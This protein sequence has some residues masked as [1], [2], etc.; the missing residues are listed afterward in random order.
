MRQVLL[1]EGKALLEEVPRPVAGPGQVL[2]RTS[3]SVLSAGTERAVLHGSDRGS[4]LR[5]VAD[6]SRVRRLLE[7]LRDEG[8]G[9]V[10]ERVVERGHP[11]AA[12]P[13]YAAAGLVEGVGAGISDLPPGTA[14]ACAGAGYACHAEW[15]VVPRNLVHRVPDGLPLEQAAFATLGAIALQGVRRASLQIGECAVVVGLGLIGSLVI[16]I[17]RAAGARVVGFDR[18]PERAARCRRLGLEA[19][20]LAARDPRVEVP[21][22]TAGL[23]ADAVLVC[24]ATEGSEAANLA[25]RLCRKKG[26]VVL[27]GDVGLDLDR[28]LMY[29]KELDL[30][31]STS[32]GPGR[33]DP[34]YEEKGIDY[35][36]AYV[37]WTE[38]RN[39]GAFLALLADGRVSVDV[40]TD[41]MFPLADAPDAYRAIAGETAGEAPLGVVLEYPAEQGRADR[42]APRLPGSPD[43][44]GPAAAAIEPLPAAAGAIGIG[45]CGAGHFVRAAHLPAIRAAREFELRAVTTSK[46]AHSLEAARRYAIASAAADLGEMLEDEEVRL[47]LIGTRHHL[48]ATQAREALAAGKHL[49]VEKPLCLEE[50]ELGPLLAAARS[51]RRLLAVG[52]N[53]RY[54]PLARRA[55]EVLDRLPGPALAVYRVNAGLLPA[56]HWVHDPDIG[57]GRIVGECCHFLDLLLHLID[58]PLI[59]IEAQAVPSDGAT[60][61]GSD[62]FAALLTFA[63]GSR[64]TLLY[65]GLG[66]AGLEKERVEIFKGGSALVLD[67]FRRLLVHGAP[68]GS[69]HLR[70]QDKGIA[71]Q[72]EEVARALR[73]EPTSMIAPHEVEATMRATFLLDRAVRGERCAS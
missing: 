72:W 37:R 50:G 73:G 70:Q 63:R 13:G 36:A 25:M 47:I 58:E 38:N 10:R 24:A 9:G 35:P 42:R 39:L 5:D 51:A 4:M 31:I 61:V 48:H 53:R 57:G 33:Y 3:Y 54:S 69:M 56:D 22:A 55:R 44:T 14:V 6:P 19:Y 68:G 65:T 59:G 52:F 45:L 40:L 43:T 7:I 28:T 1:R 20:D 32:Y 8:V 49:L 15:I 34:S 18:D 41:R 12:I 23:L 17:A 62:S 71:S 21:R 27:V 67:D 16:Q 60:V 29:E 2:V 30:L 11:A 66:D 64:A 46:P 26:R